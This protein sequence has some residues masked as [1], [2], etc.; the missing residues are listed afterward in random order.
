MEITKVV[1]IVVLGREKNA[2]EAPFQPLVDG[3]GV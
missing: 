3:I 2:D 1:G